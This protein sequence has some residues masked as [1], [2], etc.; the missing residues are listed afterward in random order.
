MTTLARSLDRSRLITVVGIVGFA[1]A[2]AAGSQVAIPIPGTPVPITLQPFL[3]VLAGMM[4]GPVAGAASMLLYIAA[5]MSGLPVWAPIGA[6][7]IAR[8]AGPTGGYLIAYPAAAWVAGALARR[9]T[10]FLARWGAAIAGVVVLYLGGLAQLSFLSGGIAN[11]IK[12]G[13]TPFALLDGAKA[14]VA[15]A[16][17]SKRPNG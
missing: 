11:A 12:I 5:G 10:S 2:L 16:I 17:T 9:S 7:G 8:L 3:V 6:P 13:V 15:A 4:L 14:L 1:A